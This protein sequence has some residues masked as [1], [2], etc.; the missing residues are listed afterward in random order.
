MRTDYFRITISIFALEATQQNYPTSVIYKHFSV[1]PRLAEYHYITC[2]YAHVVW[3][4]RDKPTETDTARNRRT[5]T[6]CASRMSAKYGELSGK[7]AR[8]ARGYSLQ[9][10]QKASFGKA[11]ET[12][13]CATEGT[14]SSRDGRA[15]HVATLRGKISTEED[16]CNNPPV[17]RSARCNMKSSRRR[18]SRKV[19]PADS[20]VVERR[21]RWTNTVA[22]NAFRLFARAEERQKPRGFANNNFIQRISL[23]F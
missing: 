13:S 16:N 10:R 14:T 7:P 20:A 6:T 21:G 4:N 5:C 19:H 3:S 23:T 2:L 22:R 15:R 12:F 9:M 11:R 18:I 1:R 17:T 8:V